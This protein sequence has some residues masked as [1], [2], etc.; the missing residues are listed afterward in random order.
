[1][2]SPAS[3]GCTQ[4][5]AVKAPDDGT[6]HDEASCV[7]RR[8]DRAVTGARSAEPSPIQIGEVR[9]PVVTSMRIGTSSGSRLALALMMSLGRR[10]CRAESEPECELIG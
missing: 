6:R 8:G 3:E 1:M 2:G 7:Q 10:T 5:L 4:L 9:L